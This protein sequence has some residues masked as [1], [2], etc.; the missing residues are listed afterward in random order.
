MHTASEHASETESLPGTRVTFPQ[1]ASQ[2][3]ATSAHQ[4]SV[5]ARPVSGF[6]DSPLTAP[7][8]SPARAHPAL[9]Q[10]QVRQ[11]AEPSNPVQPIPYSAGPTYPR[12][13]AGQSPVRTQ[14]QQQQQQQSPRAS[15]AAAEP[16]SAQ[17]TSTIAHRAAA[18]SGS[19]LRGTP[20]KTSA[21]IVS[22]C[23]RG[24]QASMHTHACIHTYIHTYINIYTH[25]RTHMHKHVQLT[26]H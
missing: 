12:A 11:Y 3:R 20:A 18:A 22:G 24:P 21:T 6:S 25:A 15:A 23:Y 1:T 10:A 16:R 9:V 7:S 17:H 2:Y 19:P 5:T 26:L 13:A 14:Q 4:P 8:S